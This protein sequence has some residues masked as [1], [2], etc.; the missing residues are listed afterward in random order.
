M[1]ARRDRIAEALTVIAPAVPAYEQNAIVDHAVDSPGLKTA[2][3]QSAAWAALV[4][5]IRHVQTDYDQ[6]L[7]DGY[8]VDSA[9]HFVLDE[10]NRVLTEWG[11]R[12]RIGQD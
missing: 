8:D 2:S 7:D 1:S 6:L 11:C 4:A 3:P 5:H 9:R 12:R 10:I